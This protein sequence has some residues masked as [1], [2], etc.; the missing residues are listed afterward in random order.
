MTTA[1]RANINQK[2]YR[3]T[4]NGM[5]IKNARPCLNAVKIGFND[6]QSRF[7]EDRNE[8]AFPIGV[9]GY[10]V[11]SAGLGFNIDELKRTHVSLTFRVKPMPYAFKSSTDDGVS[12]NA[13]LSVALDLRRAIFGYSP[14]RWDEKNSGEGAAKLMEYWV[15]HGR[16]APVDSS[17]FVA[18]VVVFLDRSKTSVP[19]L[20]CTIPLGGGP[21]K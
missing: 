7:P 1:V 21:D 13:C 8:A 4:F 17:R 11:V 18:D 15:N 5:I 6:H 12:E 10:E 20:K 9:Y 16:A 3:D 14:I 2:T 19:K